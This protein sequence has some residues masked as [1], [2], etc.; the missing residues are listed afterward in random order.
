MLKGDDTI[1]A[2][3]DG[4]A[5]VS[6]G[7][8]PAL[9]TAGHRRRALRGDRRLPVQGGWTRSTP[10]APACSCTP[11]PAGSRPQTIGTEGV[12]ARDVIELLPARAG[13]SGLP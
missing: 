13:A 4:R 11:A 10:P 1:V 12:I 9:A 6:R 3:P 5:A 7:G 8:A 2:E